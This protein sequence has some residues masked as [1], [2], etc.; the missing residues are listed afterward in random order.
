MVL[1]SG[2]LGASAS[3]LVLAFVGDGLVSA[4]LLWV[5]MLVLVA[6]AP[7]S[8]VLASVFSFIFTIAVD[9]LILKLI[10]S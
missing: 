7:V 1:V 8:L 3:V 9:D 6:L 2:V 4:V 5:S 10:A